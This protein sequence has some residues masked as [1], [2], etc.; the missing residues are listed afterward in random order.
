MNTPP[1]VVPALALPAW[2]LTRCL[3]LLCEPHNLLSCFRHTRSGR[4]NLY[5]RGEMF[6]THLPGKVK[7]PSQL[8]VAMTQEDMNKYIRRGEA[9]RLG[10]AWFRVSSEVLGTQTQ[11]SKAPLSVTMD[12]DLSSNNVYKNEMGAPASEDGKDGSGKQQDQW[13]YSDRSKAELQYPLPVSANYEG[14]QDF[15]GRAVRHGCCKALRELWRKTAAE[16]PKDPVE[17]HQ[18]MFKK[19]LTKSK[20]G[21]PLKRPKRKAPDGSV[22]REQRAI[23]RALKRKLKGRTFK[24]VTNTHLEGTAVGKL[25]EGGGQGSGGGDRGGL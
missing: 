5:P 7:I 2:F 6:L 10:D 14:A 9:V 21:A 20:E 11:R 23:K 17:L 13:S 15:E 12:Q 22:L 25:L 18:V 3:V 8:S 1:A 16:V 24:T 19:G 4:I